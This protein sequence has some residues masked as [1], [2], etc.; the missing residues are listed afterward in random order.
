MFHRC[1]YQA[2]IAAETFGAAH[3]PHKKNREKVTFANTATPGGNSLIATAVVT[4]KY[5]KILKPGVIRGTFRHG[6][7]RI[8]GAAKRRQPNWGF[9]AQHHDRPTFCCARTSCQREIHLASLRLPPGGVRFPWKAELRSYPSNTCNAARLRAKV[10]RLTF[11]AQT[12]EPAVNSRLR[13][14]L[15]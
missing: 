12:E 5:K 1:E 7:P 14:F 11:R 15:P 2:I 13:G 4:V 3:W 10:R 8:A 6:T 9:Y